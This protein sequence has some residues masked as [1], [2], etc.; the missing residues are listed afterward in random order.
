[1]TAAAVRATPIEFRLRALF[2][3][4]AFIAG[5]V[6]GARIQRSLFVDIAPTFVAVGRHLGPDGIAIAAWVAAAIAICA[7]LL[8]WWASSYHASGVVM[9]ADVIAG[10]LM[11]AGPYR[12]VRN[13]LYLGNIL[14]ALSIGSLGPPVATALV[15]LFNMLFVYRLVAIEEPFLRASNGERYAKY[16][17]V[18]PRLFPRFTPAPLPPD[19]RAPNIADGFVTELFMLGFAAAMVYVAAVAPWHPGALSRLFWAWIVLALSVV[20][21]VIVT[22]AKRKSQAQG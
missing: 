6:A 4:I 19:T 10:D 20:L 3:S 14:L 17:A 12:Y 9:N 13:P 5:F 18:V 11:T 16:C 8:R 21:K 1:M 2:I 15:V 7:W 22:S